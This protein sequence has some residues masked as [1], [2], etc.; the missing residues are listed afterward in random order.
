MKKTITILL[1]ALLCA[2]IQILQTAHAKQDE[3]LICPKVWPKKLK[4][5]RP[6]AN[7]AQPKIVKLAAKPAELKIANKKRINWSGLYVGGVAGLAK[8]KSKMTSSSVCISDLDVSWVCFSG[9][10]GALD[11]LPVIAAAGSGT[12]TS[13]TNT[14]GVKLGYDIRK[15]NIIFGPKIDISRLKMHDS[16]SV[17]AYMPSGDFGGDPINIGSSFS[18]NWLA[19]AQGRL[20]VVSNNFLFYTTAGLAMVDLKVSNFYRDNV[21]GSEYASN[22]S[23]KSGFVF[24]GGVEWALDQHWSF[25]AEYMQADFGKTTVRGFIVSSGPGEERTAHPLN[26]AADLTV[27]IATVG[28]NYR[29]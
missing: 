15:N 8:G 18:T 14:V 3:L 1:A 24:G 25:V 19:T 17:S 11:N 10:P 29:F 4:K 2:S 22:K 6:V 23:W 13:K 7:S 26:I 28:L 20:G 16:R 27:K 9:E 12:L 21:N 5:S